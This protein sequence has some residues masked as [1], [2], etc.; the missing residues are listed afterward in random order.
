[1][2]DA[3]ST[4]P[5]DAQVA[6]QAAGTLLV[7]AAHGSGRRPEANALIGRH[8]AEIGAKGIFRGVETAFLTGEQTYETLGRDRDAPAALVVRHHEWHDQRR[9]RVAPAALVVVSVRDPRDAIASM[10]KASDKQ[11]AAGMT[12]SISSAGRNMA[13]LSD[14]YAQAYAPLAIR[15]G[16]AERRSRQ[17]ARGSFRPFRGLHYRRRLMPSPI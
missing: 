15:Q 4:L 3:P 8:A 13:K 1:M 17:P 2:F 14:I 12:S 7:L 5:L 10:A 11:R 9:D 6:D 16:A